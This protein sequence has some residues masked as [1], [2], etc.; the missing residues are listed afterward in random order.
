MIQKLS[1]RLTTA[2]IAAAA[3]M[4]AFAAHAEIDN[5]SLSAADFR[6]H[7]R[8]FGLVYTLPKDV[9][10]TLDL[11]VRGMLREKLLNARL[12]DEAQ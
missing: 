7:A 3:S 1:R 10:D 12:D 6:A 11:T 4:V 9:N 8:T 2:A 5:S